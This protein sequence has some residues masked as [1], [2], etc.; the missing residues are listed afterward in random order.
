MEKDNL[1]KL[2]VQGLAA[3]KAGSD[4]AAKATD[5]VNN[6]ARTRP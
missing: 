5:E 3:M 4:V 6:D 2:V 1:Q